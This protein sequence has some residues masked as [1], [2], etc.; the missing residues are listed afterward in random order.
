M[1]NSTIF[2]GWDAREALVKASMALEVD[3]NWCVGGCSNWKET[4]EG[5]DRYSELKIRYE[6]IE[7]K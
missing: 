2:G 5:I 1:L 7:N 3:T 4:K 6:K